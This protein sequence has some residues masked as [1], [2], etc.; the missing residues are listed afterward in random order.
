[1]VRKEPSGP[2]EVFWDPEGGRIDASAL[3]GAHAIVHLAGEN[4]G[5]GDGP[6]AFIGRWSDQKKLSI[7]RSRQLGTRLLA[8]T[9]A[10]LKQPPKVFI[11][12]SGVGYYGSSGDEQLDESRE[13]GKGFLADVASEWEKGTRAASEAGIRT[14]LARLGVILTKRGGAVEKLY[15]PFQLGL[16]GPVGSGQQWFSWVSLRDATRALQ[17][18]AL[19]EQ[20]KAATASGSLNIC[21]EPCRQGDFA[22]ALGSAMHRPAL[23]PLPEPAVKLVFG[24][25]GEETLL[26]SL[27][28]T[29]GKLTKE[30]G[31]DLADPT[32]SAGCAAAVSDDVEKEW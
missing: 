11:S 28:A 6:L 7:M 23:I 19:G 13:Q 18:L 26:V 1:M 21:G 31:F 30:L 10:G 12:A 5:S 27:R 8:E 2:G 9:A 32:V 20:G 25:M 29:N 3:E 4:I 17:F 15:V 22:R 14:V 24:E 16:G